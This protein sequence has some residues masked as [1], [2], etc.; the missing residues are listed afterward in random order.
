M[1]IQTPL[2]VSFLNARGI[3]VI[4]YCEGEINSSTHT[5][6][7]MTYIRFWQAEGESRKTAAR[8]TDAVEQ[9]VKQ[10]K[11]RGGPPP[12]GYRSV[13]RGTLNFKGKPIFDVEPDP[14]KSE[15]VKTIYRLYTEEHYGLR[16]IARYLNDRGILSERGVVWNSAQLSKLIKTKTYSGVYAL[17]AAR[18]KGKPIIESPLMPHLQI[19]DEATWQKAQ[20]ILN[21]NNI[22]FG[23]DVSNPTRHGSMLLTGLA[24]CGGCGHKLTSLY[25]NYP[26]HRHLPKEQRKKYFSYRC[27][28]YELKSLEER[29]KPSVWKTPMLDALLIRDAKEFLTT[30]DKE[31][32]LTSYDTQQEERLTQLQARLDKAVA[33]AVKKEREIVKLKDEVMKVILGESN[34]TQSLLAEML[35]TRE[36]ELLSLMT[37]QEEAQNAVFEIEYEMSIQKAI[38]KELETWVARFDSQSTGDK[39]AM[40]INIIDRIDVFGDR[41][42]V[43]YKVKLRVRPLPPTEAEPETQS[44]ITIPDLSVIPLDPEDSLK[45]G[46]FYTQNTVKRY[47][48]ATGSKPVSF[49]MWRV[50]WWIYARRSEKRSKSYHRRS[51]LCFRRLIHFIRYFRR[52]VTRST[53]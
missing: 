14:E 5:D 41:M 32:L 12:Y 1:N 4:S 24:Y 10:G 11:W 29:C 48:T 8:V 22:N 30:L 33:E 25:A 40:L 34:F 45:S 43:R 31:K 21:K 6:K 42:E 19:V 51:G 13:S 16:L 38:S 18:N 35:R 20:E 44:E 36:V 39:K 9:M 3:K 37:A 23:R 28:N 7:L 52:R 17:H 47:A 2:I 26:G 49:L 27:V 50:K 53:G 46:F 15:V